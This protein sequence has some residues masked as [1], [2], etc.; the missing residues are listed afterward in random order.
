MLK[1]TGRNM[2]KMQVIAASP[3]YIHFFFL[4]FL[5]LSEK[6]S[7]L[8]FNFFFSLVQRAPVFVNPYRGGCVQVLKVSRIYLQ[9]NVLGSVQAWR[10]K[11][12][13]YG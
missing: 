7:Y 10:R 5:Q 8:I 9:K 13:R 11:Q 2:W 6:K 1:I 4:F 12:M 3:L